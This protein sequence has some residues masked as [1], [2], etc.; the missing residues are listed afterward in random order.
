MGLVQEVMGALTSIWHQ[1]MLAA[2]ASVVLLALDSLKA[3]A[4]I[5]TLEWQILQDITSCVQLTLEHPHL[6]LSL[7]EALMD[8]VE[9]MTYCPM[10]PNNFRGG[11]SL[12]LG[13]PVWLC[14]WAT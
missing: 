4:E 3:W 5:D 2:E 1:Y 13:C 9:V 10:Q 7:L 8:L 6:P 14:S 12:N 11:L